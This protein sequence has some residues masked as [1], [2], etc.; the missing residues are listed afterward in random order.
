MAAYACWAL[1]DVVGKPA[2]QALISALGDKD[3]NV[4]SKA[5][6]VL[7]SIH[8]RTPVEALPALQ[9]AAQEKDAEVPRAG[10]VGPEERREAVTVTIRVGGEVLTFDT[11]EQAKAWVLLTR[12]SVTFSDPVPGVTRG[13]FVLFVLDEGRKVRA[14]HYRGPGP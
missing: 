3:P 11:V 5:A 2:V 13:E 4:R 6:G 8:P 7:G 1:R 10:G 12:P 14:I 9:Q